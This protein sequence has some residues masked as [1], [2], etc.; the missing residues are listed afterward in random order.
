MHG[1]WYRELCGPSVAA[2]I[3]KPADLAGYRNGPVHI[4][5]SP[6]VPPPV[7]AVRNLLPEFF[8]QLAAESKPAVRVMLGHFF[9]Y[10][11]TRTSTATAA[12]DGFR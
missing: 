9:S 8:T 7:E 12:W 10:I 11:S 2:G 3:L 4:R 6:H 1:E 5:R